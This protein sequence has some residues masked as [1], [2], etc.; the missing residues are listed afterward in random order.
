MPLKSG[1]SQKTISSNIGEMMK[2]KPSAAREKAIKTYMRNHDAT[3]NEAELK[4]AQAAAFT[5][6]R[7]GK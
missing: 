6:S 1:H 4:I 5:K 7:E 3:Y 2:S